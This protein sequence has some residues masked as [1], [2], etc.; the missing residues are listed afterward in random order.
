MNMYN[1]N[2]YN[3]IRQ[4]Y[5]NNLEWTGCKNTVSLHSLAKKIKCVSHQDFWFNCQFA[6]VCANQ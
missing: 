5:F 4:V 3:V 2:L 1:L 6:C